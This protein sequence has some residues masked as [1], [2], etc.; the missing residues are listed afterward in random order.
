MSYCGI[1]YAKI[2]LEVH[3]DDGTVFYHLQLYPLRDGSGMFLCAN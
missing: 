2:L 3:D 1:Q